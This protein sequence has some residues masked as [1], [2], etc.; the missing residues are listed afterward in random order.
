MAVNWPIEPCP[1]VKYASITYRVHN[2]R[3]PIALKSLASRCR[4]RIDRQCG[5][6]ILPSRPI[7]MIMPFAAGGP[8]DVIARIIADANARITR[9]THHC[10]GCAQ[11]VGPPR[12][13]RAVRAA[14]MDIRLA[15]APGR[16]TSST[17]PS[18]TFRTI[19]GRF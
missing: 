11:R 19:Y 5:G 13:R 16:R 9:P 1:D 14:P 4:Q 6:R 2:A 15:L 12:C 18:F 3:F 17:A 7:T 8:S 10:R